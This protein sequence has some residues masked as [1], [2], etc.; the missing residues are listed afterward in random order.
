MT[1]KE[2]LTFGEKA[3]SVSF[4]VKG[5]RPRRVEQSLERD[6]AAYKRLRA[7]GLQ[8]GNVLGAADLEAR[9][10]AGFEVE[11]GHIIS[12]DATRREAAGIVGGDPA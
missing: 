7:D 11:T 5:N 8:P 10:T 4:Q 2:E 12:D 1:D 3:R 9:A 6:M